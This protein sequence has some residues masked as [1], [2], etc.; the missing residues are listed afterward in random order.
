MNRRG[1]TLLEVLVATVIMGLAVVGLMSGISQSLHNAAR[2]TDYDRAA[3]LGRSQM[4]E[5]LLNY[6]LPRLTTIQGDFPPVSLGGREGGW[7]AKIT[8]FEMP[9]HP[10]PGARILERVELEIWWKNEDGSRRTFNLEAF[11]TGILRAEDLAA[12]GAG[13][14]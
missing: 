4:D 3:L 9:P 11:R 6:Q 8:P 13:A 14:P 10:G 1:F 2:V 5:L 7:R 12:M